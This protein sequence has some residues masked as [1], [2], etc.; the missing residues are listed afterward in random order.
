MLR[1]ALKSFLS[2]PLALAAGI[3]AAGSSLLLV[4]FYE[5]V[6][7]GEGEQII[8]YP[9]NAG[10]D[11]WVMQRGVE[12]MHMA[13]SYL[14]DWKVTQVRRIQ[15][16]A[17]VEPILY[18]NTVVQAGDQAWFAYVIGL[19]T[20]SG[21]AGPWAMTAGK[22][23]PERGEAVVPGVF[24]D[25]TDLG[26]GSILRIVDHNFRIV[27]LSDGTF[28]MANSVIF[29]T[30]EDVED[31]MSSLDIVSFMLVKAEE[32]F[33]PEA[34]AAEIERQVE[35][36]SALPAD[37]FLRNDRQ[38]AVQMGVET[39]ALMTFICGALAVL[40]VAFT[41][42]SQVARQR[43]ELAVAKALGVTNWMLYGGVA[44]QAGILALA[45][46]AFAGA[47]AWLIMPIVERAVP[48]ISLQLTG[49]SIV[50][51][52]IAG[53]VVAVL[54]SIIPARRIAR[55]DPLSVFRA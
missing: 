4:M 29:V 23:D 50:R 5:A 21:R 45:S 42:Y 52:G 1:W 8:A 9:R 3:A 54:A 47:M 38:L 17:E 51:T 27:G 40:L 28:S 48:M 22:R 7:A 11:V 49:V 24:A 14:S 30:R 31:I 6:W 55:V 34:L 20:P 43:R 16:V 25:M 32:G 46:V 36:V 18:L 2:E 37:E 15:G 41:V 13:T 19:D 44:L 12:N 53:L 39:V 33:A 26:I 10:A 35:K